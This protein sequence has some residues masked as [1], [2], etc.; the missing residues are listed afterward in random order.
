MLHLLGYSDRLSVAPGQT[1]RF[2]VSCDRPEYE[3]R[4][5]RLIHGDENPD[6]RGFKQVEV[7][8]AFDGRYSGRFQPI[9]G[10]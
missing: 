2:M 9:R 4:L 3:A 10:G 1:I 8:S 6:G 7:R 5:V